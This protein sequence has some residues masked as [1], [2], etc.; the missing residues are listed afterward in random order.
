MAQWAIEY[1]LLWGLI[2]GLSWGVAAWIDGS[3]WKGVPGWLSGRAWWFVVAIGVV[4]LLMGTVAPVWRYRVH[5]WEVS[6]DV[7]YTRTGWFSREWLLVPVSRIQTVDTGQGWIE[8]ILG[9]ATLKVNTASH[10][11]SS[12]VAGLPVALATRM[13]EDLAH[14][15]HDLRDDAT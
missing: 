3:D 9:L 15:A 7:V 14:R 8:R 13:A 10:T 11:G 12:E 1:L 6:A 2:F 5:R 4:G